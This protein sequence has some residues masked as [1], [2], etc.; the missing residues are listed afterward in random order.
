MNSFIKFIKYHNAV[1]IT[2]GVLFLG[3]GSAFAMSPEIRDAVGDA[4]YDAQTTVVTVDNTYIANKNLDSYTPTV[5]IVNVTEDDDYY[6]VE[7]VLYTI[8]IRDHTW[9]D[10][11]ESKTMSVSKADLGEYRD[12]GLYV[13]E[14][15]GQVI[16][17]ELA[18]L[19]EVQGIERRSVTQKTVATAYSGLVGAMLSDKTETVPGYVPVVTPESPSEEPDPVTVAKSN[20]Q[21][22]QSD[23]VQN[24]G[25][26]SDQT[27]QATVSPVVLQVIGANPARIPLHA[28]YSDLGAIVTVD[29]RV[30]NYSIQTLLDGQEV[31]S[32]QID[33]STST[34]YVV[35]YRAEDGEGNTG[36]TDRIVLVGDAELADTTVDETSI[37]VTAS[38]TDSTSE[39]QQTQE[40]DTSTSTATSTNDSTIPDSTQDTT[41]QQATTTE[42]SSATT[43][44]SSTATTTE[45][46]A[47]STT[48]TAGDTTTATSTSEATATQ[49]TQT[50]TSTQDTTT[51]DTTNGTSTESTAVE[52]TTTQQEQTSATSTTQE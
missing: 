41:Q 29:G 8:N 33:T 26:S 31:T 2:L 43:T 27:E 24:T 37:P 11:A 48:D 39:T 50:S 49:D 19:K 38:S 14:Q 3:A 18:Y 35:T 16:D 12:L 20:Q 25:Q 17:R 1:P 32:I 46:T 22:I 13:T 36:E 10:V 9:Q 40:S 6:Y 47:T 45:S 21:H 44:Q 30:M 52:E 28:G 51:T 15:L 42:E 34:S 23:G 5:Q 4:F 7:Y